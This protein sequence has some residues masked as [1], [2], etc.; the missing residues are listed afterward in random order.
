MRLFIKI[1]LL[2]CIFIF[3]GIAEGTVISECKILESET[4]IDAANTT[5]VVDT[6]N[7]EI[8]LPESGSFRK[9]SFAGENYDYVVLTEDRVI[10]YSFDGEEMVENPIASV[11]NLVNPLSVFSA[12]YPDVIVSTKTQ[13]THYSFTGTDMTENPALSIAGLTSVASIASRNNDISVLQGNQAD[14]YAFD[15]L[16]MANVP[17][18]SIGGLNNPVEVALFQDTYDAAVLE[19]DK[20]RFYYFTGT[21]MTEAPDLALS[22]FANPLKSISVDQGTVSIVEGNQVKTYLFDGSEYSYVDALSITDSLSSPSC[23]AL[24]PGSRDM[25]IADNNEVKYFMFD[26]NELVY[27]PS[28]SK[29]IADFT[30]SGYVT[31]ATVQSN[32]RVCLATASRVTAYYD[33]PPGTSITWP[34]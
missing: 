20:V 26:G 30:P 10:H 12:A 1:L 23:L 33:V 4:I 3:P 22:G 29:Q 24:R 19:Q 15:G 25:I 31:D 8:R 21:E 34:G 18:L 9:I 6:V 32:L 11:N 2:C 16:E 17:N 14:Y 7:H 13:V 28:L 5:A 27:N